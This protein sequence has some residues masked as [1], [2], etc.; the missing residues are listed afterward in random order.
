M[1]RCASAVLGFATM[2]F[3][4][5]C[6]HPVPGP[7]IENDYL[8]SDGDAALYY[9]LTAEMQQRGPLAQFAPLDAYRGSDGRVIPFDEA[10]EVDNS[11]G[12]REYGLA[13]AS[14][15]LRSYLRAQGFPERSFGHAYR[16]IRQATTDAPV[17][18]AFI[19][20]SLA[21]TLEED[22]QLPLTEDTQTYG[23]GGGKLVSY[24]DALERT[25]G[26]K[27]TAA[28]RL[29]RTLGDVY[30]ANAIPVQVLVDTYDQ[31]YRKCA[32]KKAKG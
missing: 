6:A 18:D 7:Q 32:A 24:T 8:F 28:A 10:L 15:V 31:Q 30:D 12:G 11:R 17:V 9:N 26:D 16:G 19:F 21:E 5:G 4:V 22:G 20:Y 2:L 29:R 3:L 14:G 1:I 27:T 13:A 25:G 23:A